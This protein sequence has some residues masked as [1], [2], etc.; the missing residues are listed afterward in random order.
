MTTIE[1]EV[2]DT[3]FHLLEELARQGVHGIGVAGV[4][5]GFVYRGLQQADAE[6]WIDSRGPDEEATET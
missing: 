2:S 5:E 4:V 6:R 1:I 3:T